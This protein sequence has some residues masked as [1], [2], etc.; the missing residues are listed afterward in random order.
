MSKKNKVIDPDKDMSQLS[1]KEKMELQKKGRRKREKFIRIRMWVHYLVAM[2]EKD[3]GTIPANIGSNILILMGMY[4]TKPFL[5]SIIQ[6]EAL[7]LETPIT[8]VGEITK[9]VRDKGST[10]VLDFTFKNQPFNVKLND[11]GLKSRIMVWEANKDSTDISDKEKVRAARCLYTVEQVRNGAKLMNTRIYVTIRAKTG[12]QLKLAEQLIGEYLEKVSHSDYL[13][14]AADVKE[15]LEFISLIS[16]YRDK[17]LKDVKT[18]VTDAKT[19]AQMMPNSSCTNGQK[20]SFMGV[21]ILNNTLFMFDPSDVTQARNFYFLAPSGV[22]K[23][24]LALQFAAA[25]LELSNYR[26]CGMDIKGNELSSLV[27][28]LGGTVISLRQNSYYY[29]NYFKM[30]KEDTTDEKAETYFKE[31]F[32]YAKLSLTTLAR[33]IEEYEKK[34]FDE[35]VEEFLDS[36]YIT[37]GALSSNRNTWSGTLTLTPFEVYRNFVEFISPTV[38]KKYPHT[39]KS[40]I[41]KLKPY[42]TKAGSKSYIFLREFDYKTVLMSKAITFDFG[43][44]TDDKNNIDAG[45][46]EYKYLNMRYIKSKYVFSNF[47]QGLR[48]LVMLEES[49]IVSEDVMAS[50]VED[51]TLGRALLQDNILLGNSIKKLLMNSQSAPLIETVN[52]I[53]IGKL[54]R[55]AMEEAITQF[56]L[57]DYRVLLEKLGS[58]EEYMNSFLFIDR[59]RNNPVVPVLK[60]II[61]DD[62]MKHNPKAY[63]MFKPDKDLDHLED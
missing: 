16:D 11:T 46:F 42:Y 45:L 25:S 17:E 24:V 62:E 12:S 18:V 19:F 55:D 9:Y 5:S 49:Q 4:I 31:R 48:T 2:V 53:V 36:L 56:D 35:L 1:A 30:I 27:R 59:M 10:A 39:A 44:N 28:A 43:I 8:F 14:I 58:N 29:I 13:N 50:Y 32:Q 63:T 61:D 54:Q 40:C 38:I 6:I 57:G 15:T 41:G 7:S 3:R 34:E 52:G 51:F 60:V 47:S 20:G 21:N 37:K 23:T 33:F 26:F 22:G